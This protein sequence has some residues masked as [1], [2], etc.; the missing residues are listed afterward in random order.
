MNEGKYDLRSVL[1]AA[2]NLKRSFLDD[3]IDF[4]TDVGKQA[5]YSVLKTNQKISEAGESVIDYLVESFTPLEKVDNA[6]VLS[7]ADI[8]NLEKYQTEIWK[9]VL[10][11]NTIINADLNKKPNSVFKA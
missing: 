9:K 5:L 11:L 4:G 6:P 7:D 8:M 1:V 3:A 2:A 10:C